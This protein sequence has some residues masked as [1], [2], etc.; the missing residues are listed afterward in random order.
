MAQFENL[1]SIEQNGDII[2]R[3]L[4]VRGLLWSGV[5]LLFWDILVFSERIR[6][7]WDGQE[8]G[9]DYQV[10]LQPSLGHTLLARDR[11]WGGA[12]TIYPGHVFTLSSS[13]SSEQQEALYLPHL[14]PS[15]VS[16]SL[17]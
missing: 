6:F 11:A 14:D 3:F 8:T 4:G 12:C 16:S 10:L 5:I 7:V 9:G 17:V 1:E 2:R 15:Q 13:L